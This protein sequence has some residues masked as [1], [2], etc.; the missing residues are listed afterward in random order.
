MNIKNWSAKKKLA[1][2]LL[3]LL[4]IFGLVVTI[5]QV[6]QQL[7]LR[8]RAQK[9]TILMLSPPNQ[10]VEPGSEANLDLVINPGTNY[11]NF[12]NFT[13][14][15]D[16][17]QF[18]VDQDGFTL[19]PSSDLEIIDGPNISD[20]QFSLSVGIGSDPTKVIKT[21]QKIGS[22]KLLVKDDAAGG[23]YQV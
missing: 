13:I 2:V 4:A 18:L 6:E 21:T 12:V 7:E 8:G 22:I 10:S 11:V 17:G 9:A 20:G 23:P 14:T 16:S 3:G 19:D 1:A 15:F 5:F